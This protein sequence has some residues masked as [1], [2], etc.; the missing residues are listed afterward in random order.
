VSRALCDYLDG[1]ITGLGVAAIVFGFA[2]SRWWLS[3]GVL[4]FIVWYN[5]SARRP[6]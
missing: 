5:A 4:A 6:R 3:L 2:T 1:V